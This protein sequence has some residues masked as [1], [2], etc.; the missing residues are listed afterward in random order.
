VD[1]GSAVSC[2]RLLRRYL[3]ASLPARHGHRP[4]GLPGGQRQV[5]R[6]HQTQTQTRSTTRPAR[7]DKAGRIL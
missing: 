7:F 6:D 3:W 5:A 4:P 2:P 1:H